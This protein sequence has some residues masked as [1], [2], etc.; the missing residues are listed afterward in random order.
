MRLLLIEVRSM[1]RNGASAQEL[2]TKYENGYKDMVKKNIPHKK[3]GGN[4]TDELPWMT[5]EIKKKIRARDRVYKKKVK[6]KDEQLDAKVK[7]MNQEIQKKL[8]RSHWDYVNGLF[9]QRKDE[10]HNTQ[11][12]KRFWTYIKHQRTSQAGVSPLKEN[13]RLATD[14]K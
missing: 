9:A 6:T 11:R 12:M 3:K 7:K 4:K 8:R 5:Y 10:V 13:G 1:A 14:S 2:C